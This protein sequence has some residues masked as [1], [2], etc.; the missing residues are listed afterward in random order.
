[1]LQEEEKKCK[2]CNKIK[3]EIEGHI[4]TWCEGHHQ[5]KYRYAGTLPGLIH[6]AAYIRGNTW[7]VQAKY[8]VSEKE[9][10]TEIMEVDTAFIVREFGREY[11]DYVFQHRNI[12]HLFLD[13]QTKKKYS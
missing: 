13:V 10:K 2:Q 8:Q 11:A 6:A 12:H 9:V 3:K 4:S 1:M 5:C 7:K